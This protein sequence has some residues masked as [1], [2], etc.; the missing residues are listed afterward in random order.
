MRT[1]WMVYEWNV[2]SRLCTAGTRPQ[3]LCSPI[4]APSPSWPSWSQFFIFRYYYVIITLKLL[5]HGNPRTSISVQLCCSPLVLWLLPL[6]SA[7]PSSSFLVSLTGK[8]IT[9]WA[10]MARISIK[11]LDLTDQF[12]TACSPSSAT[13]PPSWMESRAS[14]WPPLLPL[15]LLPGFLLMWDVHI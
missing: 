11:T 14:S 15:F 1:V 6:R 3:C 9:V 13:S 10:P 7:A 4:G 12:S 2:F 8:S 5:L